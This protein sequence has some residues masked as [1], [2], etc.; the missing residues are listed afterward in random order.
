MENKNE[1]S[2]N[3]ILSQANQIETQRKE[4][5]FL[6]RELDSMRKKV[7]AERRFYTQLGYERAVHKIEMSIS[8]LR[9]ESEITGQI[10][11]QELAEVKDELSS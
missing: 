9:V 6:R 7:E 3:I 10:Y 4:I 8:L 11:A 2:A 1:N 5:E